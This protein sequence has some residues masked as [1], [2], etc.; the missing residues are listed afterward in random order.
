LKHFQTIILK[1]VT[2]CLRENNLTLI[3]NYKM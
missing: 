2:F 1:N 3:N